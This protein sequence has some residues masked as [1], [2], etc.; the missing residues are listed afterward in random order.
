[1]LRK[2]KLCPMLKEKCKEADCMLWIELIKKGEKVN[3]CSL[4]ILPILIIES[5]NKK[6]VADAN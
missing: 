2:K 3:Y 5:N 6:E 4:A 1:M